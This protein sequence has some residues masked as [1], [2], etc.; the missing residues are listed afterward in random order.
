MK[1]K[2][3]NKIIKKIGEIADRR[4]VSAYLVGGYVR[5]LIMGN[6]GADIDIMTEGDG[7]QFAKDVSKELG[8]ELNS[9]YKNFET[10]LLNFENYKIE[11]VS[12]RKESYDRG[13]RKPAVETATLEEDLSR[14]DFTIN[15]LAASVNKKSFGE[16]VDNFGGLKD[17][18]S[19]II[20]TPLDPFKTFDDD[21]LRIMRAIRFASR[22]NFSIEENTFKAII[23]MRGRLTDEG[24]VSQE[25][26]TN[27]FL[28]IL[29][30]EK[31]SVG[32]DLLYRSG[33]MQEIF[34]EIAELEGV[35]QRNDF[36]HKNV[37]YHTLK[38]VDNIS[39]KTD[40]L[41][42]RFAALVHDIAKPRTKKF[43]EG[44]GWTFHS[45]EEVGARMMKKIFRKL[46]L[47][48]TKLEYV[49][50]LVRMHLRPIP[51]AKD[52]V[53]DSAIRRLAAEA[54]EE[55]EDLLTL[56][57]ADIT[58]KNPDRVSKFLEN[59]D[60]VEKRILEVQ[61]KD[62]L[63]NF[64]SPVRGDEI[65]KLFGLEPGRVIGIFKHRIEEAILEGEIP[66]EYAAAKEYLMKIKDEILGLKIN[67]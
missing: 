22:F 41:W 26:I 32:L 56:C 51:L 47:P 54:G 57:R 67:S 66:N 15:A 3:E 63:R 14:R 9:V 19:G 29:M 44:T 59:Y 49:E 25:R 5:D 62:E 58:S 17:I 53:T 52:D 61:E 18:E 64:Q 60:R 7:I 24:V 12:A 6:E 45:H 65:M 36:H 11:F 4:K 20:R 27:E 37:F 46:K 28:L 30:T 8:T 42:L 16:V 39:A 40:N 23:E 21:P 13:S 1:I 35:D 38:V 50:K 43:V 10:A 2:T 48:M 33:V 55:L 31:P 34:P